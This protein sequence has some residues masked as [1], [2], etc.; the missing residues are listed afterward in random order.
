MVELAPAETAGQFRKAFAGDTLN[1]AWYAR[2]LCPD[3]DVQYATAVGQDA[4]S[5]ELLT[6]MTL[7]GIGTDH[8]QRLTD[9]TLGLYM[10]ALQDG[11]RTFSYWRGQAAAR[12]LTDDTAALD[13]LCHAGDM[14]Y[15]SGISLAVQEGEGRAKLLKHLAD[16]RRRGVRIAFDSNLRPRLWASND[17][18]TD[19]VMKAAAISDVILPSHDDEATFFGDANPDATR[20]RYLAAGA[21]TVVVKNGP[22]EI[23]YSHDGVGGSVQ[24]DVITTIVDTT[25]AGDSFNAGFLCAMDGDITDAIRAAATLS[26]KVIQG[27]GALVALG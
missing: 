22:G 15:F 12:R 26:G 27:R 1:T 4:Q 2:H 18:M 17:E 9:R 14:I 23:I 20:D 24:P 7:A 8:V 6:F 13:R 21:T 16:A 10:I 5:D 3:W 25:A 19:W 11:E